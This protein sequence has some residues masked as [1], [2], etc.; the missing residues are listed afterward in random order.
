MTRKD[1]DKL[2]RRMEKRHA[3]RPAALERA[4]TA[5]MALGL[6]GFIG[7][8]GLLFALGVAAFAGGVVLPF[9]AGVWL[10]IAGVFIVLFATSQAFLFFSV[11]HAPSQGHALRAAEAPALRAML[12]SLRRELQCRPVDEVRITMD[13]NAGIREI[14]RL[15]F[16]GWPRAILQLGLPL[17]EALGVDELRAVV[18]HEM[19][20]GS[21]RHARSAGRIYRLHRTWAVLFHRCSG[22]SRAGPTGRSARRPRGSRVGTGRGSMRG[23]WSCRGPTSITPT[24]S[25]RIARAWTR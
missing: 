20:H 14:P 16:L 3:G 9:E 2:V 7:W 4:T 1:F 10:L 6:A 12:D 23:R 22:R 11:E 13:F 19:A 21:A 17:M 5:W 24:G 18:A 15:G 25:P 8:V